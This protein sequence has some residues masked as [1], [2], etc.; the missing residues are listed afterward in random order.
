MHFNQFGIQQYRQSYTLSLSLQQSSPSSHHF[1]ALDCAIMIYL[2]TNASLLTHLQQGRMSSYAQCS[3]VAQHLILP[4]FQL[5]TLT[6]TPQRCL[7]E[8][9]LT[10]ITWWGGTVV[11]L[12]ICLNFLS[13]KHLDS[14]N[15]LCH[16]HQII[17]LQI[18]EVYGWHSLVC[19]ATNTFL[20]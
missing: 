8:N 14:L 15:I 6:T 18:Y 11:T 3:L 10:I 13:I 4:H 16:D 9:Y 7:I 19:F 12:I 20:Q 2:I 17:F 5:E 1:H